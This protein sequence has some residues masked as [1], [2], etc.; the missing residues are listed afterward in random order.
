MPR[1]TLSRDCS[2]RARAAF[3][4]KKVAETMPAETTDSTA[5]TGRARRRTSV[6]G[7]VRI[8]AGSIPSAHL[9]GKGTVLRG[10]GLALAV[11]ALTF[12]LLQAR[13]LEVEQRDGDQRQ[14][15]GGDGAEHHR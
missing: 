3:P 8:V 9:A 1:A 15:R 4:V 14:D 10:D 6:G 2:A 11:P 5:R 13:R 12:G 7:R